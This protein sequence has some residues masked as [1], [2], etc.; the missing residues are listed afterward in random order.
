M[1]KFA[2]HV[3]AVTLFVFSSALSFSENAFA[4]KRAPIVFAHGLGIIALPYEKILPFGGEFE[5]KGFPFLVA[6]TLVAGTIEERARVLA[7][8]VNRLVPEGPFHLLGH[9][10]GGLDARLA[11]A[12]FGLGERCLSVTTLATPH[13]GSPVAD[14]VIKELGSKSPRV[15][16]ILNRLFLNSVDAAHD[17]TTPYLEGTFNREVINDPRVKY[18]SFG[19][20]VPTP[21]VWNLT[22]PFMWIT[23]AYISQEGFPENDGMVSVESAKWGEY[24]GSF[25]GD[26]YSETAPVP[27]SGQLIYSRVVEYLTKHLVS[28]H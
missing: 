23:H 3:M 22:I 10:M 14:L 2:S 20:Y 21:V 12:K 27:T 24:L 6:Q 25:V 1:R 4:Q 7:R 11:V 13:R 15:V 8:E 5:K 9:S 28:R 16:D 18:Y 19:F 26:H 17:L